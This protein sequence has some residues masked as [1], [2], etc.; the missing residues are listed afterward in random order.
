MRTDGRS[1]PRALL[2]QFT[3]ELM[4]LMAYVSDGNQD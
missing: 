1:V 2:P 3:A 4:A